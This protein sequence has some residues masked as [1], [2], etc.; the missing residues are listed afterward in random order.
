MDLDGFLHQRADVES[1]HHQIDSAA[2]V[3]PGYIQEA[4]DQ[5]REMRG[6]LDDRTDSVDGF[7]VDSTDRLAEVLGALEDEALRTAV[8]AAARQMAEERFSPNSQYP[9]I[10]AIYDRALEETA[11][12]GEAR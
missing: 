9:R 12:A 3:D 8:A 4:V 5:P 1:L 7:I 10:M 11:A 2:G 6:C